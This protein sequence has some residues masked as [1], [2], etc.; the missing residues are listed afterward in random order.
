M[1]S[2]VFSGT[3]AAGSFTVVGPRTFTR[4]TSTPIVET[5]D[6][7]APATQYLL[8]I[9]S[10]G[11]ASAVVTL[12]GATIVTPSAFNNTARR[13][14]VPVTLRQANRLT[15]EVRG[16]PEG[17]LRIWIEGQDDAPPLISAAASPAA[18]AAGWN[19]TDVVVSFTCSDAISGI[20][21]CPAPVAVSAEGAR[22]VITGEA[23]DRAGNRAQ[24]S[25]TLNIDKT[26]P[27]LAPVLSPAPNGAGWNNTDVT[28][29]FACTDALSGIA[30]CTAPRQLSTEGA[31][32]AVPGEAV[33]LAGNAASV[34]ATVNLDKTLPR[35]SATL[36]APPN[37]NGW[38]S[39]PV[40]VTFTCEDNGSGVALCPAPIT[41]SG[42]GAEQ[43]VRAVAR[44]RAGNSAEASVTINLDLTAPRIAAVLS[45]PPNAAGWHRRDV[46]VTFTC[47]DDLSGS[48]ECPAPRVVS[49]EGARQEI[50]ATVTDRSGHSATAAVTINLD[51]TAPTIA[52]AVEP[53]ANEVG[54]HRTPAVASFTCA[55]AG[56]GIASCTQPVTVTTEGTAQRIAGVARDQAGNEASA[57]LTVSV[58]LTPPTVRAVP[59]AGGLTNTDVTV[60]FVCEDA[61]SGVASC[62]EPA[63]V[64]TEGLNQVVEGT[65]TDRAGNS[66]RATVSVSIDKTK[67]TITATAA[68]AANASGWHNAAAITVSFT[69]DDT[70][71]GVAACPDPVQ[72]TAEGAEQNVTGT[73]T[74]RAGNSATVAL[75]VNLDRTPPAIV[76]QASTT[77]WTNADASVHF[78]CTDALS[79]IAFCTDTIGV[80]TDGVHDITGA[81]VDRAGNSATT[82][83]TVRV[84]K[85]APTIAALP[86]RAPNGAGWYNAPVTVTFACADSGS[87]V[88]ACTP[89]ATATA[90][91]ANQAV[92]GTVTDRAGNTATASLNL[93]LD[94]TAPVIRAVVGSGWSATDTIVTFECTD[95]GGS[96]VASCPA[97][98]VITAEGATE[99][100]GTATDLAGNSANVEAIVQIDR[101]PPTIVA[102]ASRAPNAQDWYNA[103]VRVEFQCADS[104][105]A[106]ASCP[107]PIDVEADGANQAIAGTAVDAAGNS[108]TASVTINMD[109]T[110]PA[111]VTHQNP[112]TPWSNVPVSVT[113]ECADALSGVAACTSA[114]TVSGEGAGQSVTGEATDLAGNRSTAAASVNIDLAPPTIAAAVAPAANAQG[115][116]RDA[117]TVTFEC[118]DTGSGIAA[119]A[120]P[121][122]VSTEGAGQ[123]VSGTARDVAGNAATA[124]ASV[125][126][127]RTPPTLTITSPAAN[128]VL[129]V[130]SAVITGTI[131]D[132]VSGVVAVTC[133][134]IPAAVTGGTFTCTVALTGGANMIALAATDRAGNAAQAQLPLVYTAN[135][136]PVARPG[137]PYN[138]E[139]GTPLSLSG[140]ESSDPEGQALTYAWTFGDG[141]T[142][143]G[144]AVTHTY[145]N[146][147]V[148]SVELTVR[149]VE[150]GTSTASTT[151]TIVHANRPPVA[152]AGGPYTGDAAQTITLSASNSSDPDGDALTYNWN[153]GDGT[154]TTGAVVRRAYAT[155]G[156]YT[157]TLTVTDSRGASATAN[158]QVTVRAINQRPV[159]SVGGPYSGE[160]GKAI[161]F[162]GSGSSDPDQDPLDYEW[163]FGDGGTATGVSPAHTFT[164]AGSFTVTLTVSDGRG[165]SQSASTL[166]P[167]TAANQSPT[168]R[169]NGPTQA[170]VGDLLAF[171]AS[172]SSDGD[173]DLLTFAWAF[174]DGRSAT[175]P[176]AAHTFDR[177]ATFTVTVIVHDGRGGTSSASLTLT[178]DDAP[179]E[180]RPPAADAGGPYSAESNLP[181]AFDGSK[182]SDP[183]RETL[184]YAWDF[185]DGGSGS[186]PAPS[187]AYAEPRQYTV[188]LTVT[189]VRG[190]S[191]TATSSVTVVPQADRAPPLV[192]ISAPREVLPGTRVTIRA[193]ATDNVGVASLTFEVNGQAGAPLPAAPFERELEIPAVAAPGTQIPVRAVARDAAGNSGIAS[194][195]LT[196]TTQ[197]DNQP[198]TISLQLPA[199]AAPGTTIRFTA[200]AADND[201]VASVVFGASGATLLTDVDGP[202]EAAYAVPADAAAGSSIQFTAQ[203]ADHTGNRT[204]ATG[205]VTLV[206]A[207]DT[208]PPAVQLTAPPTVPPGGT[209][210]VSA[211]AADDGG[212]AAVV[213]TVDNALLGAITS[214]PYEA[215]YQVPASAVPGTSFR[216]EA[217]AIDFAG[218]EGSAVRL[219]QLAVPP[220]T[221][222]FLVGEVYDDSTGLPLGGATITVR[223]ADG[224]GEPV[225]A[226]ADER[227]RFA[228]G[229]APGAV[230]VH[231]QRT[232]F[233][234]ADRFV[235][236]AGGAATELLDARLTPLGSS[237]EIAPVLGGTIASGALRLDVPAGAVSTP[238]TFVLTRL[239]QQGLQSPLPAGWSPIVV[240][241]LLPRGVSFTSPAAFR[242][243]APASLAPGASLTLVTWDDQARGWR[244][245]AQ[246]PVSP[247]GNT[248]DAQVAAT[249]QFAWILADEQPSV[250]PAAVVGELIAGVT[251]VDVPQ[252]VTTTITPEPRIIFYQ[253]GVHSDVAGV[254]VT[255]APLPSGTRLWA[256]T[257][258]LYRFRNGSE[259]YPDPTVQDLTL[260][261]TAADGQHL[262]AGYVATPSRTFEPLSLERGVIGIELYVPPSDGSA[263]AMIASGGGSVQTETGE[264]LEFPEGTIASPVAAAVSR[265]AATDIG[266]PVPATL[267]FLGAVDV[268][269]TGGVVSGSGIL[270]IPKPADLAADAQVLVTRLVTIQDRT[271]FVLVALGRIEG[272][273]L[274]ADPMLPRNRVE[275]DGVRSSGRYVF[276]T[277]SQPLGFFTG[278]VIDGA[279]QNFG[280][281]QVS[282]DPFPVVALS[283]AQGGIYV[284]PAVVGDVTLTALDVV[285]SDRGS[286]TAALNAARDEYSVDL[287]LVAEPPRVISL[288]PANNARNVPLSSAVVVVF[289]EPVDPATVSG[290]NAAN[291]VL[292]DAA[293]QPVTAALTLAGGNTVLTVRPSV[294]LQPNATYTFTLAAAVAD[295]SGQTLGSP[296]S[297]TF[298][299]LDTSAPP[300]PAAGT[301]TASIP[302]AS[303]TTSVRA[304]QGIAGLHDT[305]SIENITR[306]T[307][308]PVLLDPNGGFLALVQASLGDALKLK[309]VDEAG[310]E[311]T[312]DV[313]GFTRQNPDG[314]ISGVVGGAGGRIDGPN[315]TAVQVPE[316]AL[317]D[318]TIVTLQSILEAEFPVPL[319]DAQKQYFPY[320]GGVQVDFGGVTPAKYVNI[321][322]PAQPQDRPGDQWVVAQ[323]IDVGGQQVLNTVDTAKLIDGRVQTSSPPCPGVLAAGIYGLYK[324]VQPVGLAWGRMYQNGSYDGLRMTIEVPPTLAGIAMPFPVYSWENPLPI[325]L[326]M[327][328]SRVTVGPNTIRLK[329]KPEALTAADR[330]V[331]VR[332][333]TTG[334]DSHFRRDLLEYAFEVP[335]TQ[336]DEYQAIVVTT[337]GTQVPVAAIDVKPALAGKVIVTL[338]ANSLHVDVAEVIVRNL[339]PNPDAEY[340]FP[341][342]EVEFE[343]QVGGGIADS[344]DITAIDADHVSRA[345]DMSLVDTFPSPHGSGNLLAKALPGTI[346]PTL[347]EIQ[348]YNS[349]HPGAPL[350]TGKY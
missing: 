150:G 225:N 257:T 69:C 337:T 349:T 199:Q 120:D 230:V 192:S 131:Q 255:P 119:C 145:Q 216:I 233:T 132:A 160:V 105:S 88:A 36:S 136:K 215:S 293:G 135:A 66:A 74:D 106:V 110:P 55:D 202:Y 154:T 49:T 265:L 125:S 179:Q 273:R 297:V 149:D 348:A 303:G 38:H 171:D 87:G 228:L 327:I 164:S 343:V 2:T 67:P 100:R 56:S 178:V 203:A 284:A 47:A 82:S 198:P 242:A 304:A 85:T 300:P 235:S 263:P 104:V 39:A 27:A 7:T 269:L 107:A 183:D 321:S 10:D 133:G 41:V 224:S 331:I 218:L 124:S 76:A 237:A 268:S 128:A 54:W 3:A 231:I 64:S 21:S 146:P 190:A 121:V 185:G 260:Y 270:S 189:D 307:S 172:G 60:E 272:D 59:S 248:V 34:S 24:A 25:V 236:I 61:G 266:V 130:A 350:P 193:Q 176:S 140:A 285:R 286:V 208:T 113:F 187:H 326:P 267:A 277:S 280:G 282:A 165:G 339:T 316:G 239:G 256:R 42:E 70:G 197:P 57:D 71:S 328:T 101:T 18:N 299:S 234:S 319:E 80:R 195:A 103:P 324:S 314:S 322:I 214:P 68:P 37:A 11:V 126:L 12:N 196:I 213:F 318:G 159:A 92:T 152:D 83:A 227:G 158:A 148:F 29:S 278:R 271:R 254:V 344:Y 170:R 238:T 44:D 217:R 181:I 144:A 117:A 301:L 98:I 141:A 261:Q 275:M 95:T 212:I 219:T 220:S 90:D 207:P 15:V 184:T 51:K 295:R 108:A 258:E 240:A 206:D 182:S 334:R 167:V 253:P 323:V 291:A 288:T 315:G 210:D 302:D 28:V 153:L 23:I 143:T 46:T 89:P 8:H 109:R 232:G 155:A 347:A 112:S 329:L 96:G 73:A 262:A 336:R 305:V 32:Q 211:T 264:R 289:S 58:D 75:A 250:P 77:E 259:I 279:G 116:H 342:A 290:P 191:A 317:P 72:L 173:N 306:G 62:P 17:T 341:R 118:S 340:H 6:F 22:Q 298:T 50:S 151:A 345:V 129:P 246:A 111:I 244:A 245:I 294:A 122:T 102:T 63:V 4:S 201:G 35:I 134:A 312:V 48:V 346:D 161:A 188:T 276:L 310:N 45:E 241:D 163:T 194:T 186:G 99:V 243:A 252:A 33:D 31:N 205:V 5:V 311:T 325:C 30:I 139:T 13:L 180:N 14:D 287:R 79:G 281:A 127:D 53:A 333:T 223:R 221:D 332:N 93:N 138:G 251:L 142:G 20:A 78:V 147:G 19:R 9:E 283:R 26:A 209:I 249:G 338:D 1:L 308:T 313:P 156:T 162:S 247:T 222:G 330:E 296:L 65:A 94:T 115:W 16:A 97:Q 309:I 52:G 40:T 91:G 200:T 204:S 320:S 174:G 166:V 43:N 292:V 123:Q 169:I 84:D 175:G 229:A 168:A 86:D 157:A 114:Q 335:G 81:A 226:T 274:I 177:A 137:G